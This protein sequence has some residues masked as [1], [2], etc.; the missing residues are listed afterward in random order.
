MSLG[1][2]EKKKNREDNADFVLK[3]K[4]NITLLY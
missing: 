1:K 2:K 3:V 4:I